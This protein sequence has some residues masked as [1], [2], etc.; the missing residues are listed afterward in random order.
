V[1]SLEAA[2]ASTNVM[3]VWIQASLQGL[4]KFVRDEMAAYRQATNSP[5]SWV[6][7]QGCHSQLLV[8]LACL[9]LGHRVFIRGRVL[10]CLERGPVRRLI[11]LCFFFVREPA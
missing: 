4:I 8:P 11:S 3:D 6:G 9:V 10:S 5:L 1:P 7:S 2:L